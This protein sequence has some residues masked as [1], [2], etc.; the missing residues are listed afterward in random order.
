MCISQLC[1][2]C[3]APSGLLKHCT[4]DR[5]SGMISGKERILAARLLAQLVLMVALIMAL[6]SAGYAHGGHDH[7]A[8][9]NSVAPSVHASVV[10]KSTVAEQQIAKTFQ[11]SWVLYDGSSAP[12]FR[13]LN[14]TQPVLTV[15][16]VQHEPCS[17]CCAQGAC[18]GSGG[19]CCPQSV[20]A[21]TDSLFFHATGERLAVQHDAP[22]GALF[23]NGLERPPKT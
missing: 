1:S 14:A 4:S 7:S 6:P 12:S 10:V 13:H 11:S 8:M 15:S 2:Q 16:G 5:K 9:T 22:A 19:S 21:A 3:G 20:V 23:L 18:C 17:G